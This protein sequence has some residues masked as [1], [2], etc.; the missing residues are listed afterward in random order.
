M[1]R[2]TLIEHSIDRQDTMRNF[3]ATYFEPEQEY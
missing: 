3:R 1:K 2:L